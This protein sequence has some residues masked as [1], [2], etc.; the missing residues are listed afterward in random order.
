MII[1]QRGRAHRRPAAAV[2]FVWIWRI[3]R[4]H[5]IQRG[6]KLLMHQRGIIALD[7]MGFVAIAFEQGDQ[8]LP[9]DPGQ[10]R[11]I[12]DL[13]AVQ[14]EDRQ[15]R[16]VAGRIEEFVRVPTG[17]ERAAVSAFAVADDTGL[18]IRSGLSKAAPNPCDR[19]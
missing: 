6:G 12:G 18:T 9:A 5:H 13:E 10:H 15:H 2:A 16:A 17:G 11:R 14:M 4:Q 1:G 3:L 8:F 7:K 19:L